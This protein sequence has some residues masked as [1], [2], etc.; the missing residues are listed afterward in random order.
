[1]DSIWMAFEGTETTL[2]E[3]A[4]VKAISSLKGLSILSEKRHADELAPQR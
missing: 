3:G 4:I 1:M 2:R